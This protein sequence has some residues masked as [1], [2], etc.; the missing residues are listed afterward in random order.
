MKSFNVRKEI[1]SSYDK[2]FKPKKKE[3]IKST[4]FVFFYFCV[5]GGGS[6]EGYT[7]FLK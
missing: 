6:Y 4:C 3:F 2:N 1:D 7:S 5:W